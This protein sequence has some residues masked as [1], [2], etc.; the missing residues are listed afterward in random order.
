MARRG[1]LRLEKHPDETF[2]GRIG[3]GFDF[4]GFHFSRDGPT[5]AKATIGKFVERATRLSPQNVYGTVRPK[6]KLSPGPLNPKLTEGS[7]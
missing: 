7:M 5:V 3:K 6:A 2:I 4:L 1:G